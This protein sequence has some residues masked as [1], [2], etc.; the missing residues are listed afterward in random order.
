MKK[1]KVAG[2]VMVVMFVI[3]FSNIGFSTTRLADPRVR[4]AIAYAIDMDTICET[5]LEG[6]ATPS[7]S[8]TPNPE[9][10]APG[11]NNYEY[12]PSKAKELLQEA[13]WDSNYVLDVVYYYGDQ[14]TVD[15]MTVIQAYLAD[16]GIKM[17]FRKLE[18]DLTTL[19]WTPP[20]DPIKGPS[21]VDWDL[22]YAGISALTL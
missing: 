22:A 20:A 21:A 3:L 19:L 15:L 13:G 2:M 1:I 17:E 6:K 16:V 9:Y 8:L 4:Q 12:N 18:G 7:V 14:L 10:R 11:L 5:L